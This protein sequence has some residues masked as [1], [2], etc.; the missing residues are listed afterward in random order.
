MDSIKVG[1]IFVDYN[2]P[3]ALWTSADFVMPPKKPVDPVW[4]EFVSGRY[5]DPQNARTRRTSPLFFKTSA[6]VR[7]CTPRGFAAAVFAANRP[8]A[9]GGAS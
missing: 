5:A 1:D 8:L 7:S 4:V 9:R 6:E 2:K 3:T